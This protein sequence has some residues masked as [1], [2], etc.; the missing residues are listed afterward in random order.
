VDQQLLGELAGGDILPNVPLPDIPHPDVSLPKAHRD[1]SECKEWASPHVAG[2]AMVV[3][4][5]SGSGSWHV[6]FLH[7]NL[8]N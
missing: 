1:S 4:F 7:S 6:R 3:A 8:I 5:V 2:E